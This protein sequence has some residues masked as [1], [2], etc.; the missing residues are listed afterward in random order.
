MIAKRPIVRYHGAKFRLAPRI[1][2]HF[3]AHRIYVEP[4]GGGAGVLIKKERSFAEVYNDLDSE[5]VNVFRVMRDP[6]AAEHL[7][8]LV[9]LTPWSRDEFLEA[10]E[11]VE[12]PI[13]RARR[14]I[15]RGFMAFGSTSRR[16]NRTGFR[17]KA[18]RQNQTGPAD[19]RTY[20]E[21]IP[22]FVDR[23][24]GV[25]IENRAAADII[26]QQDSED[27]LFY[28]DPPYVH[29]SRSALEHKGG[30]NDCAY[31][32]EMTDDD[33]RELAAV[34]RHVRGMVVL[35]GYPTDLYD[36]ELYPDWQR[37]SFSAMADGARRREEVLWI[38]PNTARRGRPLFSVRPHRE[39]LAIDINDR[40][41][42]SI[43]LGVER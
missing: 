3:P 11:I 16:K 6:V 29:S 13:E 2:E 43:S 24:R 4:F 32:H 38:S 21:E 10:Y 23:L 20:P 35:S 14:T 22:T 25:T 17:A 33:H 27:T 39:E 34:L 1:I 37:V 18:C 40:S 8:H 12:E 42:R 15:M 36:R 9:E 5:I 41:P 19:W 7:R 26:R 30:P 28:C 31:A